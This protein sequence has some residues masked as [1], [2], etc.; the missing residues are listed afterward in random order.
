M[1]PDFKEILQ[2][3]EEH[4]VDYLIVGGYAV[5][6]YSQPRFTKDLDLWIRPSAE[7]A[8]K[9]AR[10]FRAF[11]IPMVEVSEADLADEGL[12][13]FVGRPPNAIDFLTTIKG[14]NFDAAWANKRVFDTDSGRLSYLSPTD[15]IIS[16]RAVGRH[17]DL[18]DVEEILRIHPEAEPK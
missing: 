8:V 15:L 7:N 4:D 13:Y 1:N 3:F 5:I 12:Q 17:Q 14:L 18:A 16:K 11:G 6:R 10:A 9:V 2:V